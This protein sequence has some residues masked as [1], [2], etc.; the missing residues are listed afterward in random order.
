MADNHPAAAAAPVGIIFDVQ[1][2]ALHDGPGLRTVVFLKGCPLCCVWCHNPESYS[3]HPQVSLNIERCRLCGACADACLWQAHIV[4]VGRHVIN[5]E[6]CDACGACIDA[7]NYQAL[8]IF[9]Q[10][11][12]VDELMPE[13]LADLD[14]YRASGGGVTFSGGEPMAQL[15]FTLALLKRCQDEGVHTC[16]DTSCY[17]P[18]DAFTRV[19][20]YVDLFLIDYK[21]TG[22]EL[23]K[24]LTGVPNQTILS[25]LEYLYQENA[26]IILRCPLVPGLN[27]QPD[28]LQAIAQLGIK[29]PNLQGIELM[30]YHNMGS[31]KRSR[32]GLPDHLSGLKTTSPDVIENWLTQIRQYGYDAIRVG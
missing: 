10:Q 13:I 27:D 23:H 32:I 24:Q 29:Y 19:L 4:S 7:C 2:A 15:Y 9:G 11:T 30:P 6:L 3:F 26:R 28:H 5:Y 1:R 31:G 22:S 12:T 20:P 21:A 17:A 25:N 14:F 18:Q 8:Q 16:L